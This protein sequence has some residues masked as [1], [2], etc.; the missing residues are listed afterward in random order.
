MPAVLRHCTW[1][2]LLV[3]ALLR[4][5]PAL[6]QPAAIDTWS[7]AFRIVVQG[8]TVGSEQVTVTRDASGLTIKSS[9]G[10]AGGGYVLRNAEI[11]YGPSGA[12]VKLRTEARLKDQAMLIDT[13]VADGKAVN[14]V[15]QGE[16]ASEV[17]HDIAS[18]AIFLPNNV[19]AAAQGLAYRVVG[20]QAGASLSLYV[21]P[22]AQVKATLSAVADERMQTAAGMYEVRRHVIDLDNAGTPLVLLLWAEKASGRLIRYSIAAAGVDVVREDLTSVFTREVKVFRENDQTL[23]I[24]AFGFNIGATVS[25]PSGKAAPG[26]KDKNVERL[27]AV[28][29]VGGSGNVDRDTI[30]YGVPVMGQLAGH[31]ADAGFLVVRYDKRGVG[32]S[33]GRAESATLSDYADDVVSVVKWLR[34]QKD[35]DGKRVYVAGHSEGGAVALMAA[36]RSDDIKAVVTIAAPGTK[37]TELVLDQQR[38]ALDALKLAEEEKQR[39]VDL[40][41]Q[42]MNAVLTGQGWEG[43]DEKL[44]KQADSAWFRSFLMWDPAPVMKN[45]EQPV[46]IMHGELDK[47][48][49]IQ[50]AELLNGLATQRKKGVATLVLVPGI[51][52]LLVPATTGEV[53]EYGSLTDPKVSP[54][55]ARQITEWL[56]KLPRR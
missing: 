24:P 42:I 28:V 43:V 47:Q 41:K 34:D 40:Q 48:V 51:N 1:L 55:V 9:G 8:R 50:S 20:L 21:A 18:D 23:L 53:A 2:L 6:A 22:Q 19:F 56:G 32:Q 4:G 33:G 27:P 7:A 12:P 31:L 35:V 36:T 13:T 26:K 46:L 49:P 54:E 15:T 38:R 11:V 25:R 17:T 14:K 16:T 37:G 29:L 52:H 44:R 10:I 5:G 39:R 3:A 45:V 30:A